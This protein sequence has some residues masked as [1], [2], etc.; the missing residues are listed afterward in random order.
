MK[1]EVVGLCV[2]WP[3]R[4][5]E[6][7]E[8]GRD[9]FEQRSVGFTACLLG[10]FLVMLYHDAH[11]VG[12]GCRKTAEEGKQ[13]LDGFLCG[14]EGLFPATQIAEADA[15][16]VHTACTLRRRNHP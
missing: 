10:V 4:P 7:I 3:Q 12:K 13:D 9:L 11:V 16:V 14:G 1:D 5:I 6:I 15:Q 8:D 2:L